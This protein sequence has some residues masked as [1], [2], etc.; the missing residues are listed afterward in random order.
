MKIG[1][2]GS[3]GF[4]G[5]ELYRHFKVNYDV[6]GITRSNYNDN[7]A[8]EFDIFINANG[9][10]RRYWANNNIPKD[11]EA[12]TS[13]VYKT[14]S[15]FKTEYYIY[16]SSADVY[17]EHKNFLKINENAVIDPKH[18]CAYGFHKYLSEL[19]VKKYARKY[20]I[21]RCSAIIGRN[22]K[23]G[24][25]KDL[26][27]DKPLFITPDSKLQFITNSE[28]A[29]IIIKLINDD[30]YNEIFNVGGVGT[31][32][33]AFLGKILQK[34]LIVH[35]EAQWQF[36]KMDVSKLKGLFPIKKSIEYVKEYLNE[37]I[38]GEVENERMDKSI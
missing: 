22:I 19:I 10:S 31:V 35:K 29:K 33:I 9:N 16:I 14:F 21:L 12:S 1:I 23:K 36:Y 4:L 20:L 11:Y 7:K 17:G 26:I 30:I 3:E 24:P 6:Y 34:K 2:L 37:D 15:H 8:E 27:N 5:S 13:S 38:I 18:L 25:F 28:I 32:T